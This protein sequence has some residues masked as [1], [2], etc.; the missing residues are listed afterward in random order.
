MIRASDIGG[1]GREGESD[2]KVNRLVG[3]AMAAAMMMPAVAS[4]DDPRD[5][6]MRDAA[7]RAHDREAIRQLNLRELA[8]VR[9]R[10]ARYARDWRA[11]RANR[12]ADT[13]YAGRYRDHERAMAD[14]TR[15]R[16]QYQRDMAAWR[17]AVAACRAGDYSACG[18]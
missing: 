14:Y 12:D 6:A 3:A 4:A 8:A 11:A 1:I 18:N 17:R 13:E 16:A 5:P 7:A 15:D 2:M 9:E 10:D